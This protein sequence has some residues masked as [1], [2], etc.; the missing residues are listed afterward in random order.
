MAC[1]TTQ[2]IALRSLT[3][4]SPSQDDGGAIDLSNPARP[5]GET[6]HEVSNIVDA[7]STGQ[8]HILASP[9]SP[10]RDQRVRS[11]A[12]SE[13]H[14]GS[15]QK[16]SEGNAFYNFLTN[17]PIGNGISILSLIATLGLGLFAGISSYRDM[18]WSEHTD[19]VQTCASLYVRV[20]SRNV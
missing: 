5:N 18:K 12:V 10:G 14:S 13:T 16:T 1:T 6:T 4:V 11:R 17:T 3:I 20:I 8:E 2:T 19:A 7:Q 9:H 15:R